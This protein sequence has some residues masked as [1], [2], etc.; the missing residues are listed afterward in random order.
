MWHIVFLKYLQSLLLPFSAFAVVSTE[1]FCGWSLSSRS[2]LIWTAY[3][4]S[5]MSHVKRITLRREIQVTSMLIVAQCLMRDTLRYHTYRCITMPTILLIVVSYYWCSNQTLWSYWWIWDYR[6]HCMWHIVFLKYLQSLLL[7]F[8]GICGSVYRT[9]L[10]AYCCTVSD[11]RYTK[12][13][14]LSLHNH[15]NNSCDF[16]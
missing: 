9:F 11:E 10:C 3:I 16:Q 6:G 15:A 12:I 4:W 1:H 8:S 14:Y 13:S 7:P 5:C 2:R